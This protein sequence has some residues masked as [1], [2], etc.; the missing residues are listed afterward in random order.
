MTEQG[1]TVR[2][3]GV[4]SIVIAAEPLVRFIH[5]VNSLTEQLRHSN[6]A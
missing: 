4:G 1:L 5:S 6:E 3:V 2:H